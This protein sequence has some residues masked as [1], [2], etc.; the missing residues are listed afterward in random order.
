MTVTRIHHAGITVS[1]MERS[2]G[3]YRDLLGMRELADTRLTR[4]EIATL[5][6]TDEIDVRIVNLDTNDGRIVELLQ[7]SAPRGHRVEYT[8]RD[9]GSGHIAFAVNDLDRIREGIEATGASVI[10]RDVVNAADSEGIFAHARLLY[11]RDPDGMIL[12][13][14]ELP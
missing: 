10:S 7:Y 14:V 11:V 12:E 8:S 9:P 4:P 2:L 5:L 6:G 13:L 3:F 1:D